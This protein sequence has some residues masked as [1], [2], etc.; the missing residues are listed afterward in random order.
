MAWTSWTPNEQSYLIRRLVER[1]DY[2]ASQGQV[3]ITFQA[4]ASQTLT[5]ELAR[6]P[7][8]PHP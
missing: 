6:R 8:E 4:A 2:D 3:A 1:I 7:E 5:Q